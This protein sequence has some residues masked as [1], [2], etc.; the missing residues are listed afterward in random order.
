[1]CQSSP[2]SVFNAA[3]GVNADQV[4]KTH[5]LGA[6]FAEFGMAANINEE[7]NDFKFEA[8]Y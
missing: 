6:L 8:I 4:T 5:Q 2:S 3:G 7:D 1:M